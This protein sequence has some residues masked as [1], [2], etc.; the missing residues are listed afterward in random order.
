MAKKSTSLPPTKAVSKKNL[1]TKDVSKKNLL[2]EAVSKK[3]LLSIDRKCLWELNCEDLHTGDQFFDKFNEIKSILDSY[4]KFI[5]NNRPKLRELTINIDFS[6]KFGELVVDIT[7]LEYTLFTIKI[8]NLDT[9]DIYIRRKYNDFSHGGG[10]SVS[11]PDWYAFFL[12]V[13]ECIYIDIDVL[14]N[15]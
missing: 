11:P 8:C 14:F 9:G 10:I 4:I 15:K 3:P 6:K 1:L 5:T 2:T 13:C 12:S 7:F